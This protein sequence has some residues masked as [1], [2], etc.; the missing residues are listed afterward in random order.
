MDIEP[1]TFVC[2]NLLCTQE[3]LHVFV[4]NKVPLE[5]K[6]DWV[7]IKGPVTHSTV[8]CGA[9]DWVMLETQ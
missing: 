8:Y 1:T 6:S 4:A 2:E 9:C 5:F 3:G 7:A